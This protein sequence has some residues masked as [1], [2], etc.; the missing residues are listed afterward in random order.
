MTPSRPS[1]DYD[2]I[3]PDYDSRYRYRDLAGTGRALL[4]LARRLPPGRILEA[5]C[6]T[7]HWLMLLHSTL[8]RS[9]LPA[10]PLVGLDLSPQMLARAQA[11][12][13][14]ALTMGRAA[15]LPFLSETF[16][17]VFCINA[18]HHFTRPETFIR[19]ARRL[20]APGGALFV[21]IMDPHTR[22]DAWTVYDYFPGTLE[23]DL[24]RYPPAAEMRG[25]M[26]RAGFTGVRTR[27]VELI[28]RSHLG[29]AVFDD[30]ILGRRGTSQLALLSD[31]AY[32]AGIER[33]RRE[34]Q[35]AGDAAPVFYTRITLW[36]TVGK[37]PV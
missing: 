33:L 28:E 24:E 32:Q 12:Q 29:A 36:G 1:V 31:A 19:E 5:G 18:L 11:R 37:I 26:R 20:L 23:T 27:P 3:A 25:W 22:R 14:A 35:A 9:T 13:V 2:T 21:V 10:A 16:T 15:G 17:L 30:P 34:I 7:G 4:R 6:G 8:L